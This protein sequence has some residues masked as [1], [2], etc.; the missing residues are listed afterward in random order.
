MHRLAQDGSKL[1]AQDPQASI[2]AFRAAR[3]LAA[4]N[5][6]TRSS[7][8]LACLVA[9]AEH[10]CGRLSKA[11]LWSRIAVAD[12]PE[13]AG[14]LYT[15]AHFREV[16][17]GIQA[18]RGHVGRGVVLTLAASVAYFARSRLVPAEERAEAESVAHDAW[19]QGALLAGGLDKRARR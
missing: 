2:A 12:M 18:R 8:E 10:R 3:E 16:A 15:L 11:I 9:R 17:G 6:D 1:L 14:A 13:N 7:S 4:R 19:K 5:G